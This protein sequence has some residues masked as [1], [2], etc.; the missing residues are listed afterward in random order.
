MQNYNCFPQIG[1]KLFVANA[2]DCQIVLC[3][4]GKAIALSKVMNN[5]SS[6]IVI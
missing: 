3:K 4:N 5:L 6:I 1:N 2:G